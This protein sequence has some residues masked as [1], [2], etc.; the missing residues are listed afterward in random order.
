MICVFQ[1]QVGKNESEETGWWNSFENVPQLYLS[2]DG[3]AALLHHAQEAFWQV[4][5]SVNYFPVREFN[6][7]QTS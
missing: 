3:I 1:H 4:V 5:F 2:N 7:E 6:F